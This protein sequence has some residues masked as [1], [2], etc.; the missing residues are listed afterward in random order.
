GAS[1]YVSDGFYSY[2]WGD[3]NTTSFEVNNE[4]NIDIDLD[5]EKYNVGET[6]KLLFKTPFNG[7]MLV[8]IESDKMLEHFWLNTDNRSAT[9]TVSLKADYLPN[10]YV[11]A[12]LIKPHEESDLPLT[13]AHGFKSINVVDASTKIPVQII[14]EK[15]VRSKTQQKVKVKSLPNSKVTLAA[16]DEGVLA[17]TGF[18]TPDPHGFFYQKRA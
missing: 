7:K 4:G 1:Y 6:A 10:V 2:G 17:V 8:T 14:A 11:S 15:Q 13:V 16:V 3:I 5:K 18:K 12:T 9:A